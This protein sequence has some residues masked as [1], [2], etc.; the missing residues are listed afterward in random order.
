[1]G[2]IDDESF[3]VFGPAFDDVFVGREAVECFKSLSEVIGC[4]E[5][6]EVPTQARVGVV[7]VTPDGSF[8]ER[9]VHAL[10]LAVGPWVVGLGQPMLNPVFPADAIEH[11]DA[12]L[13]GRSIAVL[14][15]VAELDSVIGEHGVDFVGHGLD[16]LCE[17][18]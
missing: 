8:F 1:M 13:R 12:V 9:A 10:D 11:V 3:W 16:Q 4:H 2:W 15:H 17:E 7:V 6:C 5:G 18:G 14:R